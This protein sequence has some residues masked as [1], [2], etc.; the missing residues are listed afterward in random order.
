MSA[1]KTAAT[2]RMKDPLPLRVIV[3]KADGHFSSLLTF[4]SLTELRLGTTGVR[5]ISQLS[6]VCGRLHFE[7]TPVNLAIA[8]AHQTNAFQ[9]A[10]SKK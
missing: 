3:R 7:A 1:T 5:Y 4:S 10:S 9:L 2:G 6:G 8:R